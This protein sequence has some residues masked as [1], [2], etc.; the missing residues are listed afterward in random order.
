MH[1]FRNHLVHGAHHYAHGA[2]WTWRESS[3]TKGRGAFSFVFNLV[4]LQRTAQA[5]QNL[6]DAVQD[7]LEQRVESTSADT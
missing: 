2:L 3:R 1:E 6:A 5:W 7:E 4:S